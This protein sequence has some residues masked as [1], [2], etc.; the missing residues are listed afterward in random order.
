MGP[1]PMFKLDRLSST[2]RILASPD[3]ANFSARK[4]SVPRSPQKLPEIFT[5]PKP[6]AA[7]RYWQSPDAALIP[8]PGRINQDF[9]ASSEWRL[10]QAKKILLSWNHWPTSEGEVF[11]IQ[12]DQDSPKPPGRRDRFAPFKPVASAALYRDIEEL[13]RYVTSYTGHLILV[14]SIRRNHAIELQE[15]NPDGALRAA[16]HPGQ[17]DPTGQGSCTGGVCGMAWLRPGV[18]E[19]SAKDQGVFNP[20]DDRQ[21]RVARD[22]NRDGVIDADESMASAGSHGL[23]IQIHAGFPKSPRSVGCQTLPPGDFE[24]FR[25]RIAAEKISRFSYILMR[26]PNQSSGPHIW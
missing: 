26:R 20:L 25:K 1:K 7:Y 24:I 14:R 22:I 19:Y 9:A 16:S 4:A 12:I 13:Q 21:M 23:A 8:E 11:A 5:R 3:A 15:M 18:Y 10:E 17:I 6:P 2:Q